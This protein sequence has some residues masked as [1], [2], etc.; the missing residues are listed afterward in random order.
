MNQAV[1]DIVQKVAETTDLK[2]GSDTNKRRQG[3]GRGHAIS[4]RGHGSRGNGQARRQTS[5][6]NISPSN[7]LLENSYRKVSS[8]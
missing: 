2:P 6:S 7:G 4:A 3:R 8:P 1:A 5:P